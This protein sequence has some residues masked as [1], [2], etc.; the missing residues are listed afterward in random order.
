VVNVARLAAWRRSILQLTV[1]VLLGRS[2][3]SWDRLMRTRT[4]GFAPS[5][6][7]PGRRKI[8]IL[9]PERMPCAIDELWHL[10]ASR[11]VA[12]V[13]LRGRSR[14]DHASPK[15]IPQRRATTRS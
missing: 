7:P 14:D 13:N 6:I 3:A 5:A 4:T 12:Y 9:Y 8:V 2:G 11:G 10:R 15:T 1:R